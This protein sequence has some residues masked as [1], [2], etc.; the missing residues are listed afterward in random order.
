M[1]VRVKYWKTAW[2]VFTAHHNERRAKRVGDRE[3][4][5]E[6]A[7]RIR[8]R[9]ALGDLSMLHTSP[10]PFKA[11]AARWLKDGAGA[12]KES[13]H[14]FYKF[15]IALHLNPVIGEQPIGP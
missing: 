6:V 15:N 5:L 12:R 11:Y 8:E 10:E 2:W 3:T 4:A 7:R 9:L 1:G 14:R 13:T